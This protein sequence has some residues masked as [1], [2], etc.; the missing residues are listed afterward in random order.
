[1]KRQVK[2]ISEQISVSEPNLQALSKRA[3]RFRSLSKE[4]RERIWQ[5]RGLHAAI[6]DLSGTNHYRKVNTDPR[7]FAAFIARNPH[8]EAVPFEE[9]VSGFVLNAEGAQN[10]AGVASV[11][12]DCILMRCPKEL[13]EERE[14]LRKKRQRDTSQSHNR[15]YREAILQIAK[16]TGGAVSS[17]GPTEVVRTVEIGGD[18]EP[19]EE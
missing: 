17:S 9:V 5:S 18:T 19:K 12:G 14:Q 13:H 6:T 2:S 16:D 8:Y 4:E 1:M 10:V 11:G 3:Q 7:H 15:E